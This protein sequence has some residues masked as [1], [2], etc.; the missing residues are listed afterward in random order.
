MQTNTREGTYV[1]LSEYHGKGG[2]DVMVWC[3]EVDRVARTNNWR[4]ARVHTIVAASLRG[5]ATDYYEEQRVNVTGWTGGNAANN[6]RDLLI[7]QFASDSTKD[8]WYGD[9]LNCRQG[10]T[11]SVEEYSNC[12]KKLQKKVDP[13]NGTPVANTIW[14]FLSG[15]NPAIALIVY[16]STSGNLNAAVETA[17]SI[18]VGYKITQRNVQQQSNL[19]LQQAASQKDSMKVL[20]ATIEKLLRQ[21]E[22]EKYPTTRPEGSI[23]IR[24]WRCNEIGH[25]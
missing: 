24:C 21:K 1:K 22:E 20:T 18:E 7:E 11:E 6:L 16:A 14:Q 15:L 4:D 2:E 17:K 9:Y 12:F 10:I 23:N 5:A 3:E 25:F 13:N 8:V 19:A